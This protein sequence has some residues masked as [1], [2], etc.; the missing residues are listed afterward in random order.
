MMTLSMMSHESSGM[1]IAMIKSDQLMV[2]EADDRNEV[3][4]CFIRPVLGPVDAQLCITRKT[5]ALTPKEGSE[6]AQPASPE[7]IYPAARHVS[8]S[9]R[10]IARYIGD[11][12]G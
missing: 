6:S 11:S 9:S 1:M 7:G 4:H 12:A 5:R 2:F 3:S 8:V 10:I